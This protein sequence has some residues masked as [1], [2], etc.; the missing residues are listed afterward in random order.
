MTPIQSLLTLATVL[1]FACCLGCSGGAV[2]DGHT[3]D[4]TPG[5]E[6]TPPAEELMDDAA[7]DD[8]AKQQSGN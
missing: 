8:Y 4:A 5:G 3:S 1:T 6:A 7:F 2:S